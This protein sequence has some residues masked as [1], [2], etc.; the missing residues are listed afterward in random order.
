M[1][2]LIYFNENDQ[3]ETITPLAFYHE[4]DRLMDLATIQ[5]KI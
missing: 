2:D 1:K 5:G 3:Q 4:L